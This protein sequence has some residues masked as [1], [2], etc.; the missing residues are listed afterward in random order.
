MNSPKSSEKFINTQGRNGV[1]KMRTPKKFLWTKGFLQLRY[2]STIVDAWPKKTIGTG[3]L[4]ALSLWGVGDDPGDL[5]P[6][7]FHCTV[8]GSSPAAPL[9]GDLWAGSPSP[10][11]S[12]RSPGIP[13]TYPEEPCPPLGA[14]PEASEASGIAAPGDAG[15]PVLQH[16]TTI[17]EPMHTA[18]S[19]VSGPCWARCCTHCSI[20]ARGCRDSLYLGLSLVGAQQKKHSTLSGQN[21]AGNKAQSTFWSGIAGWAC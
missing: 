16:I 8:C 17:A 7:L 9:L 5:S 18:F 15:Y 21:S 2:T 12:L 4:G 1:W 20:C 13:A 14:L 11:P 6:H 19:P 10:W 3:E